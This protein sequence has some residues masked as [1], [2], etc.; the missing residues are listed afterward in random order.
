M[1]LND[2]GQTY[3]DELSYQKPSNVGPR[4]FGLTVLEI[5]G[6]KIALRIR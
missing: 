3:S 1:S 6:P 2:L 4:S 5:Y